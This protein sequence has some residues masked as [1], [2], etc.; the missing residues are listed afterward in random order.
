MTALPRGCADQLAPIAPRARRRSEAR[1]GR[2]SVRQLP[3]APGR[4]ALVALD[5]DDALSPF[6]QERAREPARAR[7]DLYNRAAL[8]RPRRPR[9]AARQV[10]VEEEVLAQ[11]LLGREPQRADDVAQRRQAV[12]AGAGARRVHAPRALM[13]AVPLRRG[14]RRCAAASFRASM[15]LCGEARPS[16]RDVEGGAVVGGGAHEGQ[17]QRDVDAV[18]EGDGLERDQR[19][20]VVHGDGGIVGAPRRRVEQRI[21]GMRARHRRGPRRAAR[22]SPARSPRSPRAPCRPPRRRAD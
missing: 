8:K 13:P 18:L 6:K 12:G 5:R 2:D 1:A 21:G 20:V 14:R 10:E 15:K 16:R 11:A 22:R 4:A 17:P 19:L 9:D 3:P 7:A